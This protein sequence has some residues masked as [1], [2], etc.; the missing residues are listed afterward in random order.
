VIASRE[1]SAYMSAVMPIALYLF[2]ASVEFDDGW[3]TS[4]TAGQ[5]A[6]LLQ[7]L[8][9]RVAIGC[10]AAVLVTAVPPE[11][12]GI[13]TLLREGAKGRHRWVGLAVEQLRCC[14][15]S[16]TPDTE[17]GN[18]ETS[19]VLATFVRTASELS[20]VHEV[21]PMTDR[22]FAD[23]TLGIEMTVDAEWLV[24][25]E[26][27]SQV[28][29]APIELNGS[30]VA[31]LGPDSWSLGTALR[32]R[33]LR[34]PGPLTASEASSRFAGLIS[35]QGSVANTH[36]IEVAGISGL[37][38]ALAPELPSW[39]A[40]VTVVVAGDF[41]YFMETGCPVDVSSACAAVEEAMAS[42]RLTIRSR[43]FPSPTMR[44]Y[45]LT[46]RTLYLLP[47]SRPVPG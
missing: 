37:R 44:P 36:E 13:D 21:S 1:L 5:Q 40:S 2:G 15:S 27:I 47:A 24:S 20:V 29:H 26:G 14:G 18:A 12:E 38:H 23:E 25:S 32:I 8:G 41:T 42:L 9:R 33:R 35:R 11:A 16:I 31:G 10:S 7:A 3:A 46:N 34:N 6:Q 30:G 43:M 45:F 4:P 28:F 17:A 22:L 39:S 19:E